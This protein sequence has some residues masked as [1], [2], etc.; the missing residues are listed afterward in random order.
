MIGLIRTKAVREDFANRGAKALPCSEQRF[1]IAVI[2]SP[3]D[4]TL[5]PIEPGMKAVVHGAPPLSSLRSV[6]HAGRSGVCPSE[7]T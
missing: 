4:F 5:Q 2:R 6:L 7:A 1:D 3:V